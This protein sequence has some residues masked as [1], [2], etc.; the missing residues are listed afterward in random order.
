MGAAWVETLPV[1]RF[2]G[3]GPVTA[4]KM[5]RLGIETGADLRDKSLDF[6]QRAF[7]QRGGMVS[8]HRARRRTTARSIRTASANPRDR[9]RPSTRDL[10]EPMPR[11]RPGVLRMA[12]D[13]WAWC[14]KAQAF[15]RTVTVKVKYADFQQITRSRS[16]ASVVAATRR[17]ARRA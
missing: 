15:G 14:D 11:S 4:T 12:D 10:T 2:H 1:S 7:R 16:F 6:L 17:C 9:R 13:V 3:V 5:Q 8:R